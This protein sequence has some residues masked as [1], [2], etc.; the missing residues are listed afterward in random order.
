MPEAW[1]CTKCRLAF[2]VGWFHYGL[3]GS[4]Y[5][6]ATLLVCR[7]CGTAHAVQ[8][9]SGKP[10]SIDRLFQLGEPFLDDEEPAA[11]YDEGQSAITLKW[12]RGPPVF[13]DWNLEADAPPSSINELACVHCGQRSLTDRWDATQPCPR[14]NGA[15]KSEGFWIT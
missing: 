3:G 4:P 12:Y 5:G 6:S 15:M 10:R 9:S 13:S 8:H 2:P 1:K 11:S 7:K 14:C